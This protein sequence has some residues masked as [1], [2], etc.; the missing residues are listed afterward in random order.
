MACAGESSGISGLL[1]L[2][3]GKQVGN[4]DIQGLGQE[5]GFLVGNASD[6]S[7]DLGE[8]S[9]ANVPASPLT[10]ASQ[11]VLGQPLCCPDLGDL[12]SRDI[13]WQVLCSDFGT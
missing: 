9:T 4:G 10:F 7:L 1:F 11:A 5:K 6:A 13:R 8:G 3:P 12:P 2:A